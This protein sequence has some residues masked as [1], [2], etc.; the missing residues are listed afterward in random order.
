FDISLIFLAWDDELVPVASDVIKVSE[1]P[2]YYR[3]EALVGE[4]YTRGETSS[5]DDL[6][7]IDKANPEDP[8]LRAYMRYRSAIWAFFRRPP[9]LGEFSRKGTSNWPRSSPDTSMRRSNG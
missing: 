5:G 2:V 7:K 4:V 8:E 9:E 3:D 6:R 1:S